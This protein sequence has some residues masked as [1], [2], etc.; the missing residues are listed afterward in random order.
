MLASW[1][2]QATFNPPGLTVAVAKERAIESLLHEG[3]PFVLNILAEGKQLRRH[4]LKSFPPGADRFAGIDLSEA[5]NG[6]PILTDSL[7]YL[8]CTVKSRMEC[9]DHWLVYATTQAGKVFDSQGVT[10]IHHRKS[11]NQ[12]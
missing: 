3:A 8:E 5:T 11:G 2:S 6:C 12:Y 10:A 9:G 7:A 4:F 1:V